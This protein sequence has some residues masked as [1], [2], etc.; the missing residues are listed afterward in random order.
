MRA[1]GRATLARQSLLQRSEASALEMIEHLYGLQ[2]QAPMPPYFALWARLKNFRPQELSNLIEN[3]LVV[4]IV[5]MRGTVHALSAS[6]AL[7]LR[8]LVQQIMDRDLRTNSQYRAGLAGVD[9]DALGAAGR[10]LV[11]ERPLTQAQL[12]PHLA[13]LFP[14]NDP[15]ALAHGVR[16]LLPL[17]QVPPRGVWGKSGQP[18]LTTLDSWVGRPVES[19]PSIEKMLLRYLAAFGPASVRDAQA[20][21]GL[22]RLG[23]VVDRL[24]SQLRVF[25]SDAGVELF[26]LPDAPRPDEATPA[27]VRIL[28]PFDNVLLSHADRGRIVDDGPRKALFSVNG[29]V[30]PAVLVGGR[31]AGL[32]RINAS[33]GDAKLEVRPLV[34]L[35]KTARSAIEVEGRRLLK[36]AHPDA[37][38]REVRFLPMG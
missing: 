15:N 24:R 30:S 3:R 26:D 34:G 9:L 1:L 29:I 28:A 20:W 6:D 12:R 2:A 32:T 25:R 23:E 22:T 31:V 14:D 13:E 4:R 18:S 27:P 19:A 36:F 10:T 11:E 37:Q 8:P 17:V 33:N 21:S 7:A 5:V 16:G 38:T 35:T